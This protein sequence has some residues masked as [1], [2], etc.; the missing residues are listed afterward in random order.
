M[1]KCC[2]YKKCII[3]TFKIRYLREKSLKVNNWQNYIRKKI[4]KLSFI[5]WTQRENG[6]LTGKSD[7]ERIK[8]KD[9]YQNNV[10]YT[11]HDSDV[12]VILKGV[13][14]ITKPTR[15]ILMTLRKARQNIWEKKSDFFSRKHATLYKILQFWAIFELR[16]FG[17]TDKSEN[18]TEQLMNETIM[19]LFS[20]LINTIVTTI[21]SIRIV[22]LKCAEI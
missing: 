9:S 5:E 16:Y 2:N 20:F 14:K 7:H 8:Q 19:K 4:R 1:R 12:H 10:F 11:I 13:L 18:K 15:W 6:L 21:Q 3:K 22:R 17:M